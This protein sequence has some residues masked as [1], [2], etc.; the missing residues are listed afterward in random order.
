[1]AYHQKLL[2][3]RSPAFKNLF[4]VLEKQTKNKKTE[5]DQNRFW[6]YF[7][8][9]AVEFLKEKYGV[10]KTAQ[11]VD[12]ANEN[13]HI[14][15]F[16]PHFIRRVMRND[17][18]NLLSER[19]IINWASDVGLDSIAVARKAAGDYIAER[20]HVYNLDLNG[21][22]DTDYELFLPQKNEI[23]WIEQA[24]FKPHS[25]IGT[26]KYATYSNPFSVK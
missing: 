6:M 21:V 26:V 10:D 5:I 12:K 1:M 3:K 19:D 9:R 11:A 22:E 13:L 17:I 23:Q 7:M 14:A 15:H 8:R 4:C 2:S 20:L 16:T 24:G 18:N 25:H